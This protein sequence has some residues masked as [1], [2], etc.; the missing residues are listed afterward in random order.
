MKEKHPF[1]YLDICVQR[2]VMYSHKQ[3]DAANSYKHITHGSIDDG[4]RMGKNVSGILKQNVLSWKL[5]H[6]FSYTH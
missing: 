4:W 5:K 1:V 2:K 6:E 3:S